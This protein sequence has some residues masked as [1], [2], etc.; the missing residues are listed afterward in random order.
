MN[1]SAHSRTFTARSV[2]SFLEREVHPK[3]KKRSFFLRLQRGGGGVWLFGGQANKKGLYF[4]NEGVPIAPPKQKR[5][6]SSCASKGGGGGGAVIW[7]TSQQKGSLLPKRGSKTR[8]YPSHP[9]AKK[10]SF[11]L[12]LQKGGGCS[13]TKKVFTSK[14]RVYPLPPPPPSWTWWQYPIN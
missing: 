2:Q 10:R 13:S 7:L 14:T 1:F 8:V 3:A 11:F 5:G 12:R 4:Q 6:P 9:Q